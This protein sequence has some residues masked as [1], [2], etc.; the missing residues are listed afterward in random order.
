MSEMIERVAR[1]MFA[2]HN[3]SRPHAAGLTWDK[4]SV[5]WERDEYRA[6]AR[7]AIEAMREPT[8]D[9]LTAIPK[10]CAFPYMDECGKNAWQAMIN[11]AL[12]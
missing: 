8:A 2:A 11:E 3:A 6:M 1:A 12:K 10:G 9:M 5:D 4:D 7:A